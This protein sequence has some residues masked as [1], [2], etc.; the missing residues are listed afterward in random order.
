MSLKE[1]VTE[2]GI[3]SKLKDLIW[4]YF[5]LWRPLFIYISRGHKK[6]QATM[7]QSGVISASRAVSG[8]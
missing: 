6:G 3:D 2:I 5:A 4:H 8:A 7:K 1:G